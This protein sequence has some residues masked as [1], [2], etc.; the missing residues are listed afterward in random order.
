MMT[1]DRSSLRVLVV[2]DDDLDREAVRR[3]LT[4]RAG[5]ATVEEASGIAEAEA[6]M[7]R[8]ELDCII[9]DYLLPEGPLLDFLPRLMARA[10]TAAFIVLTGRGDEQ[11]AVELMKRGVSD[12]LSKD[13]LEPARLRRAVRYAVSLRRAEVVAAAAQADQQRDTDQLRRIVEAAPSLIGARTLRELAQATSTLTAVVLEAEET[14]VTLS[15]KD[16]EIESA[17]GGLDARLLATWARGGPPAEGGDLKYRLSGDRLMATLRSRDGEQRG[18]IAAR[19]R[20]EGPRTSQAHVIDQIGVLVAVCSDN[21]LLYEA[22]AKAIRARDDILA[23]V[24]HDLRTPLN[25]VR[26]GASLL[27][28]LVGDSSRVIVG[29]ID[30]SITHMMHLVDDLVDMVRVDGGT[31]DLVLGPESVA[32]ILLAARQMLAP[33]A[34][35]QRI[36]LV[37]EPTPEGLA[38]QADRHR[39]LQI[40][41]NLLGNALK[42]TPEGGQVTLAARANGPLVQFEVK[43][44]G[45]GISEAEG[46]QIF[47]RF[48][49][50]DPKNRRGLGLGLYIAKGLVNAHGGRLWFESRPGEGSRFFFTLPAARSEDPTARNEDAPP[51][52]PAAPREAP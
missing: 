14:F 26:L 22:A 31:I 49:R 34:D 37:T 43:D 18:F 32:E 33:Q 52:L 9:L 39:A 30:R 45:V 24:S 38:I 3:A 48:W 40:L 10:R 50:S 4:A 1:V 15:H 21:I 41:A 11:I 12:Y 13:G 2:D 42:F 25:N 35:A 5:A 19:L 7:D 27:R 16:G 36:A 17:H 51:A 28:D 8:A 29:R 44:S 46:Q 6:V 20:S 23:V 47:E